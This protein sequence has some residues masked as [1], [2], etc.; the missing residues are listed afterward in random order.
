MIN[1]GCEWIHY[2]AG[3]VYKQ[4]RRYDD[5]ACEFNKVID[6]DPAYDDAYAQ[7]GVLNK[8]KGD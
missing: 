2:G 3:M 1:P 6:G 5:A 4:N 8:I 7:L